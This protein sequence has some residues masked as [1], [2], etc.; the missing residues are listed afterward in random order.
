MLITTSHVL[1]LLF[2]QGIDRFTQLLHLLYNIIISLT[3]KL[4]ERPGA[5]VQIRSTASILRPIRVMLLHVLF[6]RLHGYLMLVIL[7]C[8]L[9]PKHLHSLEIRMSTAHAAIVRVY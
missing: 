5:L 4:T 9:L 2:L 1:K 8:R 6:I 3:T 7:K